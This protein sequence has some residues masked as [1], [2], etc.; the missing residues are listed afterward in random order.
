MESIQQKDFGNTHKKSNYYTLTE[1]TELLTLNF[2]NYLTPGAYI[3]CT[4]LSFDLN[5]FITP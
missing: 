1:H 5:A 3:G 4:P 2:Y